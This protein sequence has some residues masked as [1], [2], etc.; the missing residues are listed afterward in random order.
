MRLRVDASVIAHV[1]SLVAIVAGEN[2]VLKFEP[3]STVS[4]HE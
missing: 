2:N 3:I 4:V 1:M